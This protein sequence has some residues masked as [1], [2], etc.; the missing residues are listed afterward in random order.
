MT[1]KTKQPY[2]ERSDD[3]KLK[4]NWTKA[5]GHY[6]REDWSACVM[7]IATSSEIAANIYVRKF[8]EGKYDLPDDF[9]DALLI[10]ANGLNGKFRKLITP[11]AKTEGTWDAIKPIQT[12]VETINRHRNQV[13]HSG[14]FKNRPDAKLLFKHAIETIN[15]LAPNVQLS[16]P[17]DCK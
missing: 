3:D 2:D 6:K 16:L 14:K 9:V 8:L 12:K 11:A 7:R 17:K 13:A 10:S 5:K 1:K 15:I 4:S